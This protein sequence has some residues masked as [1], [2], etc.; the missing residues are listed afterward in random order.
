MSRLFTSPLC[1]ALLTTASAQAAFTSYVIR[2]GGGNPPDILVNNDYVAGAT[3]FV[4]AAGGQKAAWGSD[5]INGHTIGQITNLSITRHDPTGR[6]TAGSGQAVAPYFNIWVTDGLGNYAV[7]ANE[8]SDGIFQSLFVDNGD[9]SK[10]YNL[11]YDDLADKPVKVYD[12]PNG[13]GFSTTTWVHDMFGNVPLTFADVASLT[14]ETPSE[15]YILN[16]GNAVGSGAPREL[17]TNIAY[18]F[19]WVFGDTLSNYVTGMESDEGFVVSA[20]MASA[21]VPEPSTIALAGLAGLFGSAVY[22]RRRWS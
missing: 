18:G 7:L 21:N 14:I 9:G 13:G 12:T 2:E 1:V 17:N 16:P 15:A 11:S 4:I 8:P 22:L 5:D 10:S 6:F 19:N 20:P 3:E